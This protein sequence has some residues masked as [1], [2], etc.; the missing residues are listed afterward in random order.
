MYASET[1]AVKH[2][3][4][5][6]EEPWEQNLENQAANSQL[7]FMK[8]KTTKKQEAPIHFTMLSQRKVTTS[9]VAHN[10]I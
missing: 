9:I 2:A 8:K 7:L 4:G 10:N 6:G 5:G 3:D 1:K